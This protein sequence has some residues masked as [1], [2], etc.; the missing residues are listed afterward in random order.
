MVRSKSL[1]QL[2]SSETS[3]LVS[4]SCA[5]CAQ[6]SL[7]HC[8]QLI[9]YLTNIYKTKQVLK[10]IWQLHIL[11]HIAIAPKSW[12]YRYMMSLVFTQSFMNILWDCDPGK[13]SKKSWVHR[14]MMSLHKALWI[15]CETV[16]LVNF[17]RSLEFIVTWCLYTKLYE[18]SVRLWPTLSKKS[19]VHRYMMSLHKAL[20]IFCETVTLVNFPRSLEF[21][22]T[23]CL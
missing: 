7:A 9:L 2:L 15:F 1:P 23:W 12:V 8:F 22:V 10:E 4:K 21:I 18:Y 3:C 20:W 16:T 14:Y 13:L 19:W 11:L 17:P 5:V 6:T